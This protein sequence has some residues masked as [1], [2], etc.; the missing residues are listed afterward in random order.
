MLENTIDLLAVQH[1]VYGEFFESFEE[2]E[3]GIREWIPI[4]NADSSE[5][6]LKRF[7]DSVLQF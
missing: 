3:E 7:I 5:E 4:M 6:P 2:F 1:I